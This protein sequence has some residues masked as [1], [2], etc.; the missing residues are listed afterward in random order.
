MKNNY[1]IIFFTAITLN[2]LI[3][4]NLNCAI[5]IPSPKEIEIPRHKTFVKNIDFSRNLN[6]KKITLVEYFIDPF[7]MYT[8]NL[9]SRISILP[10]VGS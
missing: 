4:S 1:L 2:F 9:K 5:K 10:G 6:Y 8:S 7:I 3:I